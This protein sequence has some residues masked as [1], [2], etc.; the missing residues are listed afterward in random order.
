MMHK[1]IHTWVGGG[2]GGGGPFQ[3]MEM[4]ENLD[5][6]FDLK[7]ILPEIYSSDQPF[8]NRS[9]KPQQ[10]KTSDHASRRAN[11]KQLMIPITCN[12]CYAQ[13]ITSTKPSSSAAADSAPKLIS[14]ESTSDLP[15]NPNL[16][17]AN[18][19]SLTSQIINFSSSAKDDS[20]SNQYH[21]AA[22]GISHKRVCTATR[23][24]WQARDHVMAER[25]RR[26]NLGQLFISL[27][28]VVPGLKKL[29]KASLL[30][31]AVNYLKA[32]QER[33]SVIEKEEIK[34]SSG[35]ASEEDYSSYKESSTNNSGSRSESAA[36]E[37]K[38]RISNRHVLINIC[39][40]KQMGLMSR[41]P[42]EM[43]KMHL[44]V[45]DMRIMPFGGV[46]L[47]IT[48]LAEMQSEF[49]GTVKDIIDHLQTVFFNPRG[50]NMQDDHRH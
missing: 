15:T 26:E 11:S 47:D 18:D 33:V 24:P 34:K 31:D 49:R 43:E 9:S 8:S 38:A 6:I 30:E 37:I 35:D 2:G 44:N 1:G 29:D 19:Y 10:P 45:I 16:E 5:E 27:S 14:F 40:K 36:P 21:D 4:E 39:C 50:D 12:S 42:S 13:E 23:T 32:L 25:K 22:N 3:G 17:M 20:G 46:A 41:I 48:V 28:K 7:P